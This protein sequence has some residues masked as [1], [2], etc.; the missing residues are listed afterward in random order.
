MLKF[1]TQK[2]KKT[3]EEKLA[4]LKD[5][6]AKADTGNTEEIAKLDKEINQAE[7]EVEE[8]AAY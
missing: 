4:A 5:K 3:A 2:N 8:W 7:R 6:K 1:K